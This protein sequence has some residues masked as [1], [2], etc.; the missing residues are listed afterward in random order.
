MLTGCVNE[1]VYQSAARF[2][3]KQK[4]FAKI[5]AVIDGGDDGGTEEFARREQ[6]H[7]LLMLLQMLHAQKKV[8]SWL[9]LVDILKGTDPD[10]LFA[11]MT[12]MVNNF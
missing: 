7:G 8:S 2:N 10:H 11:Y 9:F 6:K 5:D 4:S 12:A 1:R 3:R